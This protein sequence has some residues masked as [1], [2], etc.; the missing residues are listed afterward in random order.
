M[1]NFPP[2]KTLYLENIPHMTPTKHYFMENVSMEFSIYYFT[3]VF[4][5][6]E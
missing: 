5:I 3:F 6:K 1:E 2:S 4:P